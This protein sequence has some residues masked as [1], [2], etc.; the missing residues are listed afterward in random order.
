MIITSYRKLVKPPDNKAA[1]IKA[2]KERVQEMFSK[3]PYAPPQPPLQPPEDEST[4]NLLIKMQKELDDLR[5]KVA[6]KL[7]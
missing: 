2:Q 6:D 5:K 4:A 1:K 3:P 7:I